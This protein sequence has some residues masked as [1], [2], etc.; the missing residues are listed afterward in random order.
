MSLPAPKL[1]GGPYIMGIVNVTPDSFSDGGR[2]GDPAKAAAHALA[3]IEAGADIVD[4]GGESTRPGAA[5]VS[6]ADEIAR[7]V[8]VIAEIRARTDTPI[9]I[10][11]TKPAVA[12]AAFRA[13]AG[14]WNDVGAL[15]AGDAIETAAAL[16]GEIILMHMQGEPRTMQADP[17]YEDVVRE[18]IAFLKER[19]EAA[20]VGGVMR[21][22]L[23]ADP[24]F[25][26]GKTLDHNLA[27]TRALARIKAETGARLLFGAS[28]KSS[29]AKIDPRA[30]ADHRL[31]G[32]LALALYAA[33]AGADML[34]VHD[35]RETVQALKVQ[36]ALEN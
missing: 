24:G 32:S 5:P 21:E 10:D 4:I 7:V 28:R 30:D 16:T 17:R 29:I 12:R 15:S 36:R 1:E 13:G 22:R 6:Q 11:T 26:F 35:V 9:S 25:G 34:R 18:V 31:G 3:L 19:I 14:L 23:W 2:Y 33:R 27:L 20:A 8:P